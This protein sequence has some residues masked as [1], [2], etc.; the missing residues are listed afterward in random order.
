MSL[1]SIPAAARTRE[2]LVKKPG[3]S[4]RLRV[5]WGDRPAVGDG[6]CLKSGR[7]YLVVEHRGRVGMICIVL[8]RNADVE[9]P[10]GGKWRSWRWAPK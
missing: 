8:P 5:A 9:L 2:A 10:K 4:V 6:L 7:R 1:L 3:E